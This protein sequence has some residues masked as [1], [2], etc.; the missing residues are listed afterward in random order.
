MTLNAHEAKLRE[1]SFR[2]IISYH[3]VSGDVNPVVINGELRKRFDQ[4]RA[5]ADVA[6]FVAHLKDAESAHVS[7]AI[8]GQTLRAIEI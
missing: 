7:P 6:E 1:E 4:Q 8:V 2:G 3:N 5:Q